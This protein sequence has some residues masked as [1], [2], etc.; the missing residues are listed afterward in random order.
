MINIGQFNTLEIVNEVDFGFFLDSGD[1]WGQILMPFNSA[2]KNCEVGDHVDVF[3]YFDSEDRIIATVKKPNAYVGEFA[4]MRVI[5][6]EKVGAFLDWGL[7]KDLLVPFSEQKIPLKM[8]RSYV[9]RVYQD[10]ASERIVASTKLDRFMS[11]YPGL[12]KIGDEVKIMVAQK[13]ELG[14]K[15]IIENQHWG[16]L[17]NNE[18]AGELKVGQRMKAYIQQVREDG[19]IDLNLSP[20]GFESIDGLAVEILAVIRKKGG[21]VAVTAKTSPEEIHKLFGVSKKKYKMALGTL[22]KKR[23]VVIEED[24]VKIVDGYEGSNQD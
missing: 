7:P 13:T 16:L 10:S 8:G 19:K 3:I 14:Y 21:F 6:L 1:E 15:A 12:F 24:G 9:V 5:A 20:V 2:P 11:L 17:Y 22:Y 18:V 4:L 23:L